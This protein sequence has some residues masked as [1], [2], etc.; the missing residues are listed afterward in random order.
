MRNTVY[1]NGAIIIGGD[2]QGLGIAH[3]IADLIIL[4]SW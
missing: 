3:D 4:E 2:F 1:N